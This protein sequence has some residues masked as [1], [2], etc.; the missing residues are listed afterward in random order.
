MRL[1][2][3][4]LGEVVFVQMGLSQ[5]LIRMFVLDMNTLGD[6]HD[7]SDSEVLH[8]F[9]LLFV[10]KFSFFVILHK[11][12]VPYKALHFAPSLIFAPLCIFTIFT[13]ARSCIK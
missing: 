13:L 7:G 3:Q 12:S 11:I 9:D 2:C 5:G 4:E 10:F 6:C 8:C 1:L